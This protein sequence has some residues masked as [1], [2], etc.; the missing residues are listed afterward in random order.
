MI[1]TTLLTFIL[2]KYATA[3][4]CPCGWKVPE[5]GEVYTHR[6]FEDF[7]KAPDIE[8]ILTDDKAKPL[9]DDWMI[10]DF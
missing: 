10:Y 2:L 9:L 4:H 7:S 1:C 3:E 5:T 6:I 8:S